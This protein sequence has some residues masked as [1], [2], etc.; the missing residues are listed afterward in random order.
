MEWE[1]RRDGLYQ[2]TDGSDSR[3]DYLHKLRKVKRGRCEKWIAVEIYCRKLATATRNAK[4]KLNTSQ[5]VKT[6]EQIY[7]EVSYP[8]ERDDG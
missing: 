7:V 2:A 8:C 4:R 1:G 3:D 6:T 5:N